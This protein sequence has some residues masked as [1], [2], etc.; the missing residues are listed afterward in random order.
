MCL[1]IRPALTASDLDRIGALR[2][3]V[4]AE[5]GQ[6]YPTRPDGRVLDA[7]DRVPTSLNLG[8]YR[9]N[10]LIASVRLTRDDPAFGLPTDPHYG[11]RS[12]PDIGAFGLVASSHLCCDRQARGRIGVLHALMR[13]AYLWVMDHQG[14]TVIAAFNPTVQRMMT[15]LGFEALERRPCLSCA[16]DAEIVPMAAPITGFSD[17]IVSLYWARD[18]R[19]TESYHWLFA[20]PGE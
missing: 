12:R 2:H 17:H 6:Y 19:Q 18:R 3:R 4:F 9:D 11:F 1:E 20:A 10:R 16:M 15:R 14:Q 7:F 13:V 8:A 5:E